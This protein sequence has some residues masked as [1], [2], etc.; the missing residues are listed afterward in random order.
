LS[1]ALLTPCRWSRRPRARR[2]V[3]GPLAFAPNHVSVVRA[4]GR[5]GRARVSAPGQRFPEAAD[6][7][8]VHQPAAN[9]GDRAQRT[10]LLSVWRRRRRWWWWWCAVC[11]DCCFRTSYII[12]V[13]VCFIVLCD[14][15]YPRVNRALSLCCWMPGANMTMHLSILKAAGVQLS[16]GVAARVFRNVHTQRRAIGSAPVR[17]FE[18]WYEL[19][20]IACKMSKS[21]D[22]ARRSFP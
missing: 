4:A 17:V 6:N 13:G 10:L 18:V 22:T 15:T 8:V 16:D 2:Y 14:K 3:R 19:P 1:R 7:D 12:E 9:Q 21:T 11:S 20:A 5:T